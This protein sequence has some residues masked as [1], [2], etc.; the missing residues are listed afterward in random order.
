ML[1]VAY[2]ILVSAQGPL[3]LGFWGFGAKGLG[4]RLD[5]N[6]DDIKTAIRLLKDYII[7][8]NYSDTK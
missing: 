2:E 5:K 1:V 4:P 8:L 7:I 6:L 3:V